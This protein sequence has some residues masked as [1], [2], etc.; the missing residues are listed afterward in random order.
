MAQT[1]WKLLLRRGG[2]EVTGGPKVM[3][4]ATA[5]RAGRSPVAFRS[6]PGNVKGHS[7]YQQQSIHVYSL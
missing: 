3:A 2:M 1:Y 7:L 5:A 4:T 6:G